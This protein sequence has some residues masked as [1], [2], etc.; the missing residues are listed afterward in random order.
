MADISTALFVLLLMGWNGV[1]LMG[2][3]RS[4]H[5][6]A[7]PAVLGWKGVFTGRGSLFRGTL[8]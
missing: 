6:S 3:L 7:A 5:L 8:V 4:N 1:D 2:T